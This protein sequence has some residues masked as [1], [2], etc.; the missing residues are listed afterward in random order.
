MIRL[1]PGLVF[2][3]TSVLGIGV[4]L[5]LMTVGAIWARL[6]SL[7]LEETSRL[8]DDLAR[9]QESIEALLV[10]LEN[11]RHPEPSAPLA[12]AAP[13]AAGNAPE[14]RSAQS[15][16]ADRARPSAVAGPTL[17][18]VPSLAAAGDA[19]SA[20]AL[21]LGRRFGAIWKLAD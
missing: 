10:R 6:R 8:V 11:E 5:V 16:R 9:R 1:T 13:P 12:P 21:E 19:G 15:Q 2:I 18:A 20:A 4:A 3:V 7:P 14:N 17:I